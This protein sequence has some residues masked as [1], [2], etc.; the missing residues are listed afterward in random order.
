MLKSSPFQGW[1]RREVATNHGEEVIRRGLRSD[2]EV[3]RSDAW[4]H[5]IQNSSLVIHE[6]REGKGAGDPTLDAPVLLGVREDVDVRFRDS[7]PPEEVPG[8]EEIPI[9]SD[10]ELVKGPRHHEQVRRPYDLAHL[11][12]DFETIREGRHQAIGAIGVAPFGQIGAHDVPDVEADSS[13][14]FCSFCSSPRMN[15]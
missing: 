9:R 12:Q 7:R 14:H 10:A 3:Q 2:R 15:S 8:V 13:L 4:G 5:Q 11:G 1:V 6:V